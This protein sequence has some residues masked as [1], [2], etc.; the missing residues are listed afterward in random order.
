MKDDYLWDKSGEPD[1]E[2]HELENILGALKYQPRPLEI[3]ESLTSPRRRMILPMSLAAAFVLALFGLGLWLG[4][5]RKQ[6]APVAVVPSFNTPR[7]TPAPAM[8]PQS[9]QSDVAI[10][11]ETP[12]PAVG[13]NR[14]TRRPSPRR[15]NR[16]TSDSTMAQRAEAEKAKEQLFLALRLASE[17]LNLAQKRTQGA[18][19]AHQ[20]RN[21]H[22]TG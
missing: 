13:K 17:K 22:K 1:A 3:P 15:V 21:Q 12:E 2:I 8:T 10:N 11:T 9:N 20:I 4:L 7:E 14:V 18:P 19:P 6:E 16:D 5:G